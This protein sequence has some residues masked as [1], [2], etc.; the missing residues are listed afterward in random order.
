MSESAIRPPNGATQLTRA[1]LFQAKPAQLQL[2]PVGLLPDV[3]IRVK[4][5]SGATATRLIDIDLG[6]MSERGARYIIKVIDSK[7]AAAKRTG[8]CVGV[9][10]DA[11]ERRNHRIPLLAIM[12]PLL[13]KTIPDFF[14]IV[15]CR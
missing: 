10:L 12:P 1:H 14:E 3:D 4:V 2:D 11:I 13:P 15:P 7:V 5:Y 8:K 9:D 6:F